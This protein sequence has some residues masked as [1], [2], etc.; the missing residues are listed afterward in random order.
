MAVSAHVDGDRRDPAR[1]PGIHD[2]RVAGAVVGV[3]VEQR[4]GDP[5]VPPEQ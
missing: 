5:A 2:V 1:G 3:S 4:D